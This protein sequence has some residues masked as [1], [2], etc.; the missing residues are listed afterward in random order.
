MLLFYRRALERNSEFLLIEL[1]QVSLNNWSVSPS[2][3]SAA[4]CP[5]G[6][7]GG[8]GGTHHLPRY[9]LWKERGAAGL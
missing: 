4:V 7:H 5:A 8:R 6:H 1:G 3:V 2:E 9:G